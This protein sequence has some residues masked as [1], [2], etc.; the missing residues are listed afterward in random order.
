MKNK[1]QLSRNDMIFVVFVIFAA[2]FALGTAI[3]PRQHVYAG[4][5]S[6]ERSVEMVLP[7]VD[8]DGNGVIAKLYTVV[9][10]GSGKILLDTSDVLN[11][12]DTQVSG[13]TAAHAAAEFA[14][15]DLSTVDVEYTIKVNASIVEG[16]SAGAAMAISAI[17]AMKNMTSQVIAITGTISSDGSIGRVGAVTEKAQAVKDYGIKTLLIPEGQ[18]TSENTKRVRTCS[19]IG[20]VDV[21]SVVYRSETADLAKNL[22]ISVIEVSNI[23]EAFSYFNNTT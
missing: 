3:A 23:A 17:L 9:K 8:S 5:I 16:P 18:L 12:P 14:D 19:F 20:S 1:I 15:I 4:Q 13:R 22:N 6:Q 11:Y 7:A 2:G 21:C 10:P